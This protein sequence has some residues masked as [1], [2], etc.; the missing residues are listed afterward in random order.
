MHKEKKK[1]R[2]YYYG[3]KEL[4]ILMLNKTKIKIK[5]HISDI[6]K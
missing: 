1:V 2:I 5:G 3:T 4:K 6:F